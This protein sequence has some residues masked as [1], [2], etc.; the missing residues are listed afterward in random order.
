MTDID[1]GV[2]D[3]EL[4]GEFQ[5]LQLGVPSP[6]LNGRELGLEGAEAIINAF[7]DGDDELFIT[8]MAPEEEPLVFRAMA[9]RVHGDSFQ[10]LIRAESKEEM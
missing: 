10:A 3:A 9:M 2:P 6:L 4:Q 7:A 8:F 1:V 5:L